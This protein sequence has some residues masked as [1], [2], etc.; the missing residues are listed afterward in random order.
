V[1]VVSQK[2]DGQ[3]TSLEAAVRAAPSYSRIIVRPGL[4]QGPIVL[5]KPL[6]LIGEGPPEDIILQTTDANSL[7]MKAV[8]A[9]V[10]GFTIRSLA[11]AKDWSMDALMTLKKQLPEG[12]TPADGFSVDVLRGKLEL[13][14]CLVTS[15]MICCLR[16]KGSESDPIIRNCRLSGGKCFG[17]SIS[18]DAHGTIEDCTILGDR[19][20]IVL[21]LGCN[22]TIRR[23]RIGAGSEVGIS[24]VSDARG[25]LED[26][27]ITGTTQGGIIIV[28]G[29][30]PRIARCKL[31]DGAGLGIVVGDDG[32]GV[33]EDCE[34]AR[35]GNRGVDILKDA[36]PRIIRCR[37]NANKLEGLF[38]EASSR[39]TVEDCDLTGNLGG[40][41]K[42]EEG[43]QTTF[44]NIQVDPVGD[45]SSKLPDWLPD[46]ASQIGD[47]GSEYEPDFDEGIEDTPDDRGSSIADAYDY[48]ARAYVNIQSG[49]YNKAIDDF[50]EAIRLNPKSA[51]AYF[52]RGGAFHH[53]GEYDRAIAD[54]GEAIRLTSTPV[55]AYAFRGAAYIEKGEY[56]RAIADCSEAIHHDPNYAFAYFQR[57]EAYRFTGKHDR[58]TADYSEAIRLDAEYA[59]DRAVIEARGEAYLCKGEID[60]AIADFNEIIHLDPN[61]AYNYVLRGRA[62]FEK[63]EYE[64]A[65]A[66]FTEAIRL[67][68]TYAYAYGIRGWAC[69]LL[70]YSITAVND[71]KEALRLDPGLSWAEEQ[72]RLARNDQH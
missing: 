12:Q 55:R 38:A 2:G 16:I 19:Y 14:N 54:F 29:S 45:T 47:P 63:G 10:K 61:R 11:G 36:N 21:A 58:A 65:I 48:R 18:R 53:I 62:Y 68:P 51:D 67:A 37:I 3:Y 25:I 39:G 13:D 50:G 15:E 57:G 69:R 8:Y 9:L 44:R 34:I 43:C 56:D 27:T 60:R 23:C 1:L 7:V 59:K 28:S 72:L 17:I 40:A 5:D 24:I 52:G 71:L 35:N 41:W 46:V 22:P 70:G 42:V 26:C 20:S 6:Q 30:N 31:V 66:D 49:E 32:R 64:Q 4:Y 33:I